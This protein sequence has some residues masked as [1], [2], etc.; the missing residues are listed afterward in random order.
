ML[1]LQDYPHQQNLDHAAGHEQLNV[2][3]VLQDCQFTNIASKTP[4][5][6][7]VNSFFEPYIRHLIDIEKEKLFKEF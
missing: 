3:P 7:D 5:P 2:Y 1:Y 6:L 4:I